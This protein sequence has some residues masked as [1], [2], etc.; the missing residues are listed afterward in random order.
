MIVAYVAGPYRDRRGPY[1]ISKNIESARAVAADVWA[2]GWAALCPHMNTALFDG[3]M[4]DD[5]FLEGTLEL[6]RR[7]DVL[8]LAPGWARSE[9]TKIEIIEAIKSGMAIYEHPCL[10]EAV[11]PSL[12]SDMVG[13]KP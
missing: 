1:W 8:V 9:G 7:A 2:F 3:L 5:V 12:L 11:S 4:H 10:V 6:M 13:W